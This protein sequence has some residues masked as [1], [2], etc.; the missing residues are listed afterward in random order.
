MGLQ[1]SSKKDAM[2][3]PLNTDLNKVWHATIAWLFA[4][5]L[6]IFLH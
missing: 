1:T 5:I 6:R 3:L 4:L 2:F